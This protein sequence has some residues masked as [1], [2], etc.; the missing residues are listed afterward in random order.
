MTVVFNGITILNETNLGYFIIASTSKAVFVSFLSSSAVASGIT[1]STVFTKSQNDKLMCG[2]SQPY[3]RSLLMYAEDTTYTQA[4]ITT[5]PVS[6]SAYYSS[7]VPVSV[8]TGS[9]DLVST[10]ADF[11]LY[12]VRL[13]SI[14]RGAFSYVT[15]EGKKFLTD[16]EVCV[17]DDE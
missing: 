5:A 16:G 9:E 13:S 17:T 2:Y 4:T 1:Y 14:P 6:N 12:Y 15:I 11:F 10:T 8:A 7:L 3:A